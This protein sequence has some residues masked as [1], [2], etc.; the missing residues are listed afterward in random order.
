MGEVIHVQ[1]LDKCSW[2]W[3]SPV[4]S[5]LLTFDQHRQGSYKLASK[6]SKATMEAPHKEQQGLCPCFYLMIKTR[7]QTNHE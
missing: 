2:V 5:D 1:E 6:E 3:L 7:Y 4:L